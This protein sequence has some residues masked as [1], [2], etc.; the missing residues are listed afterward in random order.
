M[1]RMTI[2]FGID[3]GTTNS[4]IAVVDGI[5]AK[6]IPNKA[7]SMIT[8]SA[9]WID[10]RGSLH[11]G[12]EAKA[13]ALKDDPDNGDL[14]FKL[15]M[16]MRESGSKK[17]VRANREMLPEE[18]SAEV[19]KSLK[20]DVQTSMGED[21]RAAVV[22]VPAAF[23]LPQTA[24]TRRAACGTSDEEVKAGLARIAGAGFKQCILLLEPVAASLAYGFQSASDNVYWLVFDFGGG[25][26][27]SALMRVRDGLIQVV[28]HDGDNHLGG[29]LM[30]W[31]IVT[32]KLIPAATSQHNLPDFQR[33][34]SRWERAIGTLKYEAERAKIEVCRT[35]APFE[36]YV[37]GLC[38]DADG[39]S[40]DFL[41]K[42]TPE[43]VI[44]V[45][46]PYVE[47][48]L[49]LCRAVLK[50]KGLDGSDLSKVLMVGGS[51]LNP[52]MR[53]AV[54]KELGAPLEYS[55]DPVTVVARGAAIF[56]STQR[57]VSGT[58]ELDAGTW[59]IEIEHEPVGNVQDPD[60]GGR[61]CGPD[62]SSPA[63]CT[64]EF[65]DTR[66]KW[67]SGRIALGAE[68]VFMTQLFADEKRR[69]EY[70]IE[71]SDATG[72]RLP[73]SPERV[74]YTLGLVPDKPPLSNTIGIGLANEEMLP[75][76]QKGKRLPAR[77]ANDHRTV[78]ALRAGHAEDVLIIPILE[79][80]NERA[81]RNHLIG[82][83]TITGADIRR[84]LHAGSQ[85]E[86]S[87]MVDES[88][89]IRAQAYINALD[90][91][92]QVQI[93]LQMS[94]ESLPALRE[95]MEKQKERLKTTG[96]KLGA[97]RT[98]KA[99][100]A[101]ARIEDEQLLRQVDALAA[102]AERDPDALQQLDRRLRDLAAAVDDVEDAAEWPGLV[103]LADTNKKDCESIVADHG[104]DSDKAHLG[105]LIGEHQRAV[106]GGDP[107]LLRRVAGDYDGLWF[108]VADRLT[109]YHVG[110]FNRLVERMESMRDVPQAEQVIAQGRRA[111]NNNDVSSLKA[112]NRQLM[113][114]LPREDQT[115][116]DQRVGG[117]I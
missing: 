95:Q 36:I 58:E 13:R 7:G 96:A 90:E 40:V 61:V 76:I 20:M 85:V 51:T 24:A 109:A 2:D 82:T 48:A 72:T 75:Y 54:E 60:I 35:R 92:F 87:V 115:S 17:F 32:E 57:L 116:V 4:T 84:D 104:D 6:P 29:K 45:G 77:G 71:L 33:A 65:V 63:G 41:Y 108:I 113:N 110:R 18:L 16:G 79:G 53:E 106:D 8:P 101:L 68:G 70:D 46:K 47:R 89:Q 43:D 31:D 73:V 19:L 12:E 11:V 56:A 25:T 5:D 22:T 91:D 64:I 15:R 86:V 23:E 37:E 14:E 62:G 66:T 52:W 50:G 3:L 99:E 49:N 103:A 30:D 112:A 59:R 42:L 1:K 21:V 80:E 114:M 102:A 74:A 34:N 83:I 107:G 69:C 9:V 67:R 88:Q 105:V 111:I 39:K 93:S 78:V 10:K 117:L 55:I 81:V 97:N 94:H 98:L 38:E 28:N 100:A 44:E 26:F 27:D